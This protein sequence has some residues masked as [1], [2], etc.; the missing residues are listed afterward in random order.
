MQTQSN[1]HVTVATLLTK[2]IGRNVRRLRKAAKPKITQDELAARAG[3]HRNT[4]VFLENDTLEG[5]QSTTI[6][7]I[8]A[9]LGVDPQDLLLPD[10]GELPD[11]VEASLKS[12]YDSGVG[13]PYSDDEKAKL[14]RAAQAAKWGALT[15]KGW[16]FALEAI[17]D[18][19]K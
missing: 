15:N 18:G 9:A 11:D 8:A 5:I 1:M 7:S 10:E 13:G 19:K 4:I 12:F 3:V 6:E 17:R 14:R 16:L 2:V